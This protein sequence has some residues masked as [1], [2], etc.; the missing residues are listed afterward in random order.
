MLETEMTDVHRTRILLSMSLLLLCGASLSGAEFESDWGSQHDRVWIGPEYWANPMEDWRLKDGRL[1]CLDTAPNRSV[2]LLPY[3]LGEQEGTLEMSVVVGLQPG[4]EGQEGRVGFELGIQSELEDY[5]SSLIRGRGVFVGVNTEGRRFVGGDLSAIDDDRTEEI[6]VQLSDG[7]RLRLTIQ[8]HENNRYR[9]QLQVE[10]PTTGKAL[11]TSLFDS[12]IPPRRVIGNIALVHNPGR[13]VQQPRRHGPDRQEGAKFWF[14]DWKVSGTKLVGGPEQNFGPILYAMH[15]LSRGVMKMTAQMPPVGADDS[16]VV[17]L[18]VPLDAAK[19]ILDVPDVETTLTGDSPWTPI[20]RANIDPFA[21]TAIFRIPNWL[22]TEDVPYRL[23]YTMR[24]RDGDE[25]EHEF[26]G[27]VRQDPVEKESISVAGFTGHQDF[28]FPNALLVSN[29]L[30][31]DPDVLVFTGDQIYERAGGYGIIREPAEPA[32][33]NYLRKLYLWG[34]SFRN[35]LRDRVSLV[36]PDDHDVYQGNIWGESG[37]PVPGGIDDHAQG[38]FVQP[39][40]FVNAVFRTQCGHHPDFHDPTPMLQGI[41]VFYGDMVYGRISFAVLEDR[42]FKSGPEGKV[43]DWEGRPDHLKDPDYDVSKLDQPGLVLLGERQL[44][45]LHEWAQDWEGADMK[46]VCSQTIFCNLANYHGA[47]QEFIFADLDS[48]G[49]PQTGRN[50]AVDA[51]RRGMAF[52]YAG[53]QHLASIVHHGIDDFGDANWS[54]CVPSIAAGYPRSWRPDDEGRPVQNR[55]E[56]GLPNTGEYLDAFGNH[57]TVHAIGNPERENRRP[58]LELLH[59]KASGYA[60]AHFNKTDQTITMECFKL[61]F[62]ADDVQA[63]DQFPG[64]P[65]TIH[66][67]ENDG[68]KAAAWLPEIEVHGIENPVVQVIDEADGEVL[69]TLRVKESRYRAKVFQPEGSYTVKVGEPDLGV[70]ETRRQVRSLAEPASTSRLTF[71]FR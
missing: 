6:K 35:V 47:D 34:W 26:T 62:D 31:H 52:H 19:K 53:D 18:Q 54:F 44:K 9:V 8:P 41:D 11:G 39:P 60:L 29:L 15:T 43:D 69:Y 63:E 33:L 37:K 5:Q 71:T 27:T 42:Y 22:D 48:N 70:W 12:T 25:T 38:G 20:A 3:Q 61:L 7:V 17:V 67:T 23:V 40:D 14:S 16:Q 36:F 56:P 49:W 32:T 21:R 68:R 13:G 45:F 58:V 10:H 66:M 55:P 30:K 4:S 65:K 59:D 64:W 50:K 2:H 46:V 57:M 24:T 51:M 28:A 1:E